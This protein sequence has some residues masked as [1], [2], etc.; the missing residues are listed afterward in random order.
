MLYLADGYLYLCS[1]AFQFFKMYFFLVNRD[2]F[3][4]NYCEVSKF[5]ADLNVFFELFTSFSFY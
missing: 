2:T 3:K 4:L 1:T 5:E